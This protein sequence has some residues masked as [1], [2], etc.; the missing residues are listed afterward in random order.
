LARE[1]R[2][3]GKKKRKYETKNETEKSK[4]R[5]GHIK[6]TRMLLGPKQ[7]STSHSWCSIS[8]VM[9]LLC[10]GHPSCTN[11]LSLPDESKNCGGWEN[12][13]SSIASETPTLARMGGWGK[14]KRTG[15]DGAAKRRKE[16]KQPEEW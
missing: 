16:T 6:R 14:R 9:R 2:W 8:S 1:V 11:L 15:R 3:E 12:S 13:E 4:K 10:P 7:T 5:D